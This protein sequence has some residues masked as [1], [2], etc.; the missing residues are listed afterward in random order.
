MNTLDKYTWSVNINQTIGI[1][2]YSYGTCNCLTSP[3]CIEQAVLRTPGDPIF[4]VDGLYTGCYIFESVLRSSMR[5]FY[6]QSCINQTIVKRILDI[7]LSKHIVFPYALN[8]DNNSSYTMNTTF[9]E[10]FD[11]LMIE[12]W[13]PI[14]NHQSYYQTCQPSQCTYLIVTKRDVSYIITMLFAIIGGLNKILRLIIPRFV[15]LIGKLWNR[16]KIQ[17]NRKIDIE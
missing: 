7:T 13:N 1:T 5:C 6:S 4:P 11:N 8:I 3:S 2:D 14:I 10:L 15:A 9:A 12:S 16:Y 17:S